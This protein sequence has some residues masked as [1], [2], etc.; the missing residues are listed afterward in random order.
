MENLKFDSKN[1]GF[2]FRYL[3]KD[4]FGKPQSAFLICSFW[5]VQA[6]ARIGKMEQANE[7]MKKVVLSSNELGLYPEH[8]VPDSKEQL[9]NFPQAYSHVGQI[10]AAFSISPAW[11]E[12]L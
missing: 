11:N 12:I 4:D 6:L 2:L 3:R 8:F 1:E 5:L 10:N 7:I 9:G